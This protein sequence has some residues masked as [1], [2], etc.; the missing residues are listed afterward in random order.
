MADPNLERPP[1][2]NSTPDTL[3]LCV[4]NRVTEKVK[5]GTSADFKAK[6]RLRYARNVVRATP[7]RHTSTGLLS[8]VEVRESAN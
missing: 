2:Y 7:Y 8:G 3:G 6:S 5:G 4:N 1:P